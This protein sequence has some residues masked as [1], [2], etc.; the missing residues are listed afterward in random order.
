MMIGL[1]G[2]GLKSIV[3]E[4]VIEMNVT[5]LL[6]L[7][8]VG[9]TVIGVVG[10]ACFAG[11]AGSRQKVRR[12]FAWLVGVWVVYMAVLVGVSLVQRQRVVAMGQD[13]VLSMRCV[14]R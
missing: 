3:I 8:L 5:E 7:G 2:L 1:H 14:S 11:C 6:L 4:E 12:G 9:W 10:V 13:A